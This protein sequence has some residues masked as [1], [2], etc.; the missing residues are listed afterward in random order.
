MK[1][2]GPDG[3]AANRAWRKACNNLKGSERMPG[4]AKIWPKPT[5]N[6]EFG[7]AAA[8]VIVVAGII[9]GI[10]TACR[11]EEC[12]LVAIKL[13]DAGYVGNIMDKS[14]WWREPIGS[15]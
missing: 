5:K 11:C 8:H 12:R 14:R 7:R 9:P 13:D 4:D 6:D 2:R 3:Y 15:A 1:N 10:S